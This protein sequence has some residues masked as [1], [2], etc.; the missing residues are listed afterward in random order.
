[1]TSDLASRGWP[2]FGYSS[3]N[4]FA[5]LTVV[6]LGTSCN[7]SFVVHRPRRYLRFMQGKIIIGA[8]LVVGLVSPSLA[9]V[10]QP[11]RQTCA[12]GE[13]PQQ[14]QR[15]EPRQQWAQQQP[16]QQQRSKPQGCVITR[17]IPSVV[18]PTP[19][20]LL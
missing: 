11:R 7:D 6:M 3:H 10:E 4:D 1:M 9:A 13:Q 17:T 8:F 15:A 14:A 19:T 12:R 16:Q 20:F 5:S 2:A 18:D